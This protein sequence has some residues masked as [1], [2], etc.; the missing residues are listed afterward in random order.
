MAI[1]LKKFN[2]YLFM[3]YFS[4]ETQEIIMR[5]A[6]E[7]LNLDLKVLKEMDL[8]EK[9]VIRSLIIKSAISKKI[10]LSANKELKIVVIVPI[11]KENKRI[12]PKSKDNPEGENFLVLKHKQLS[13]LF[14]N[15]KFKWELTLI[16]DGCPF[17]S[18]KIAE[19]I[20]KKEELDNVKVFYL[21]D[22]L[23]KKPLYLKNVEES[24]KGGSILQMLYEYKDK[25][26][27]LIY[28]DADLSISLT[29]IGYLIEDLLRDKK[30]AIGSRREESSR[31]IKEGIRNF[32]GKLFIYLWKKILPINFINDTQCAFKAFKNEVIK[33][34]FEKFPNFIEK[35]FAF[36]IELLLKAYLIFGKEAFSIK[37]IVWVDSTKESNTK[38]NTIHLKMLKSIA[39][40]AKVYLKIDNKYINFIEKL[41]EKDWL[42]LI[43]NIPEEIKNLNVN[44][45]NNLEILEKLEKII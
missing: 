4:E 5:E 32:R 41:T 29:Q 30:I 6:D 20:I 13:W 8:K 33:E 43:D 10:V 44:E 16:D 22:F 19:E 21:K 24:K 17:N 36:D 12:L 1:Y 3:D 11:Y 2:F 35:G 28:T 26:D 27:I 18:G 9:D 45:F 25:A 34:I 23:D 7:L 37:G 42:K 38:D 15:S 39:K 40:M 14:K 31:V